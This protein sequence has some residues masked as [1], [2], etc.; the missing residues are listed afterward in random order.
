MDLEIMLN[1]TI[2][3]GLISF[4]VNSWIK[5]KYDKELET[6]KSELK[7]VVEKQNIVFSKLHVDRADV[8]AEI[9]ALIKDVHLNMQRYMKSASVSAE[10]SKETYLQNTYNAWNAFVD[11]YPKKLIYLPKSTAD[12]L[13]NVA[14]EL[15]ALF[16]TYQI[17][18]NSFSAGTDSQ[19][20]IYKVFQQMPNVL[21]VLEN[22]FRNLL[23]DNQ[24]N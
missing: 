13:E 10:E 8:I 12:K 1:S 21:V 15:L 20:E 22:E 16:S 4:A 24:K 14:T 19:Q 7:G 2:V 18:T 11:Y 17:A 6:L 23:G 3:S 9:Y 5:S